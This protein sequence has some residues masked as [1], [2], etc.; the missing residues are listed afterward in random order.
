MN[1][2]DVYKAYNDDICGN[3]EILKGIFAGETKKAKQFNYRPLLACAALVAIVVSASFFG[4]DGNNTDI[5]NKNGV[6]VA[7]YDE[8]GL[9]ADENSNNVSEN[10]GFINKESD[11]APSFQGEGKVQNEN[12][13]PV[14]DKSEALKT[15]KNEIQVENE[16]PERAETYNGMDTEALV[17]EPVL[18][19]AQISEYSAEDVPESVAPAKF[20]LKRSSGDSYDLSDIHDETASGGG[21]APAVAAYSAED[22]TFGAYIAESEWRYAF[23]E[24]SYPYEIIKAEY[25]IGSDGEMKET[26]KRE[27]TG[28]YAEKI[29]N[30]FAVGE[31]GTQKVTLEWID[32]DTGIYYASESFDESGNIGEYMEL[33]VRASESE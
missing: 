23:V 5:T 24:T 12:Y 1:F 17:S 32:S 18:E 31:S 25:E 6:Y 30:E 13:E 28:M 9:P 3:R 19:S 27:N 26:G 20:N 29:L 15:H 10:E 16:K 8:I 21:A 4:F 2:K 14:M 22:E 11:V 33:F 7:S